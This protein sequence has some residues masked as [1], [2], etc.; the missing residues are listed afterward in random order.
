[1]KAG[2]AAARCAAILHTPDLADIKLTGMSSFDAAAEG[3]VTF[4]VTKTLPDG[5]RVINA[6]A[7]I[8]HKECAPLMPEGV[9][10]LVSEHPK[11]AFALLGRAMFP[12][13]VKS[14]SY[15]GVNNGM[16]G[17]YVDASASLED[18]V[19]VSPGAVIG[20]HAC[21]G[22]GTLIGPNVVIGPYC[23]IGRNCNIGS[24][25]SITNSLIGNDVFIHAGARIGQ[26]GFGYV[27]GR[28]GLEKVPHIGRV[29]IQDRVEIGAN[30][31]VDR[32]ML[33]DTVIGEGT[34]IDNLVQVGHNARIGRNCII[35]AM[36]GISGSV[37]LGDWVTLGG[38]VGLADHLT[39]GTGAK[40]AA[41]SGVICDIPAGETWG[42]YPAQ[43]AKAWLREVAVMRRQAK[44][45][46]DSV[47]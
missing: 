6:S 28:S 21:I 2:E 30:T 29:I 19:D 32:G 23:Q 39:I 40:L 27:P 3:D 11:D 16:P 43:P 5:G 41:R 38:S 17:T 31:T 14:E 44:V 36:C 13:S 37:T 18:G 10:V 46:K 22:T 12:G 45:R 20:A 1:M 24:N 34:K 47:K 9:A 25:A 26:D 42:G 15:T 35:V 8:C 33:D 4:L 7:V